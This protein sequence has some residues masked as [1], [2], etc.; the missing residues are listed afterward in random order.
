[1]PL[2]PEFWSVELDVPVD[3]IPAAEELVADEDLLAVSSYEVPRPGL[4]MSPDWRLQV[5]FDAPPD[6][7]LWRRRLTDLAATLGIAAPIIAF[8]HLP[9]QDRSEEHT[10]ELPS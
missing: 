1:M 2:S 10:S 7:P 6:E 9:P 5:L 4:A 8:R 3:L